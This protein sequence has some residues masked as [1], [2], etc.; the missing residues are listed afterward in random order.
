MRRRVVT[1]EPVLNTYD[2]CFRELTLCESEIVKTKDEYQ[3]WIAANPQGSWPGAVSVIGYW[4]KRK[5]AAEQRFNE[6]TTLARARAS[7]A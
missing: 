6:L 2:D 4:Q 3:S 5:D 1:R 7:H